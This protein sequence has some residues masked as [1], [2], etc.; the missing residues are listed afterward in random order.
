MSA[1]DTQ[2]KHCATLDEVA[3]RLKI[4]MEALEWDLNGKRAWELEHGRKFD[5]ELQCGDG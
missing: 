1:Y 5:P 2:I 4:V 3:A